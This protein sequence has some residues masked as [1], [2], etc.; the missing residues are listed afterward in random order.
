V[1]LGLSISRQVVEAHHGE[2]SV[3]SKIDEG[4]TFMVK[5]PIEDATNK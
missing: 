5:L 4:S 3:S 1:G 2:I